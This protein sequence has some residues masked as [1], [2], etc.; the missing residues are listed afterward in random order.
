MQCCRECEECTEYVCL[1][2]PDGWNVWSTSCVMGSQNP[3]ADF[4]DS[5]S[6]T[7]TVVKIKKSSSMTGELVIEINKKHFEVEYGELELE[8]VTLSGGSADVSF[9]VL[10]IVVKTCIHSLTAAVIYIIV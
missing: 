8:D 9:F 2:D 4:G 1:A 6:G 7:V 10:C 3:F 5:T